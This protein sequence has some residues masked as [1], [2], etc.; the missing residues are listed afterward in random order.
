MPHEPLISV[1]VPVYNVSAYLDR[2][3]ESL[4][5]QTYNN[6]Q[7][8][9]VDDGS[10]DDSG[11]KCDEWV[12]KDTRIEVIHKENGGLSDARNCGIDNAKGEYITFVDSDDYVHTGCIEKFVSLCRIDDSDI[13]IVQMVN[14]KETTNK[15]FEMRKKE[16]IQTINSEIAIEKLMY[17]VDF[18]CCAPAKMYRKNIFS[19]IRFPIGRRSED[20]AI[21]HLLL[22]KANKITY[23]NFAGYFYRQRTGSI[24]HIFDLNRLD[25]LEWA[26]KSL[27]YCA[28]NY[29][30]VVKA[31]KCRL[32]NFAIHLLLDL[33]DA[34]ELHDKCFPEIWKSIVSTRWSVILNHKSR[35]RE[36]AAAM[37]SLFGE[38][39]LKKVWHSK[40]AI[41][42]EEL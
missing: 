26:K 25:A 20:A 39:T 21:C 32:F 13:V 28:D 17:Q 29:P 40:L 30:R 31:A 7:I 27:D 4:V 36:K 2:C 6:L 10:T 5:S 37:L 1:I 19:E 18:G 35:F 23:T 15:Q 9:L 34:G 42:R 8:L 41:R 33:P 24:M 11:K 38:K 22:D 16:M 3:V 12:T 14:V